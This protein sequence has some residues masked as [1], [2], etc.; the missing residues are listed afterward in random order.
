L[1]VTATAPAHA[2]L[3]DPDPLLDEPRQPAGREPRT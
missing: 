1:S 3:R 2:P